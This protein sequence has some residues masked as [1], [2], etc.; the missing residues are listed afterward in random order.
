VSVWKL[1]RPW[2]QEGATAQ[3]A[4]TEDEFVTRLS[5]LEKI[6]PADATDVRFVDEGDI[7]TDRSFRDAWA[8]SGGRISVDMGKAREIHKQRLR[9]ARKPILEALDVE[10]MRADED[11]DTDKKKAIAARKKAL[12]DATSSPDVMNA[13]T[14]QE[15]AAAVPD[16]L[17]GTMP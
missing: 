17:K 7:P 3:W 1:C 11:G 10:Y 15:L 9:I 2:P 5:K 8:N 16:E 12:R 6:V 4:E 14:P 13:S